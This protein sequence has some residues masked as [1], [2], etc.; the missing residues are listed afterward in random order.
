M[1]TKCLVAVVAGA[2]LASVPIVTTADGIAGKT[3]QTAVKI[4]EWTLPHGLAPFVPHDPAFAPDGSAWYTAYGANT[5]GRLDPATGQIKEYPLPTPDSGPHGLVVDRQGYVWYTANK[6]GAIG[7]LDPKSG[8][9]TEYK[10]P[11]PAARDPHTPVFD[12]KG[13]LWFTVQNGN[14]VGKLDPSTGAIVLKP[15]LTPKAMPH[16]IIIGGDGKPIYAMAGTNKIGRIDPETMEIQEFVLPEGAR[17]RRLAATS[18]GRVWYGD[19][20][21]GYLG[22]LDLRT[23]EVKEFDAA[24]GVKSGPYSIAVT[25]GDIVWYTE[26]TLEPN[27]L[28]RFDSKT[29]TTQSW[30]M[31]STGAVVRHT[32]A[33]PDGSLWLACSG[34]GKIAR[35]RVLASGEPR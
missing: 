30:P 17:P 34:I 2:I 23:K 19:S 1:R 24:D 28:V 9:V 12:R 29:E 3:D 22:R 16:G 26:S 33:A 11:D 18:D 13:I 8:L 15:S 10:M 6:T 31:P 4:D 14:F 20:A 7:K 21:R 25:A 35:A 5:L 27:R 32:V